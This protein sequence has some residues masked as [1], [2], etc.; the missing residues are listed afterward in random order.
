[1]NENY[2]LTKREANNEIDNLIKLCVEDIWGKWA[3]SETLVKKKTVRAFVKQLLIEVGDNE[4]FT[5]QD[6]EECYQEMLHDS[7]TLW[8]RDDMRF[9]IK[10]IINYRVPNE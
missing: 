4:E 1:M 8:S 3:G 9:F 2:G 6:F 10:R 7:R 5:D